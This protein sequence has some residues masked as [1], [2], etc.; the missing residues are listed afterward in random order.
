MSD[1]GNGNGFDLAEFIDDKSSLFVTMGVFGALALYISETAPAELTEASAMI[2]VGF[3]ASFL[4]AMLI[5]ALIYRDLR[6][7]FG[8]WHD[9]IQAH[10]RFWENPALTAFTFLAIL[11]GMSVSFIFARH[12]PVILMIGFVAVSLLGY[13]IG[14][15]AFYWV[16]RRVPP[17]PVWRIGTV[18]TGSIAVL[19]LTVYL[20]TNILNVFQLTPINDL[21]LSDPVPVLIDIMLLLVAS[22]QSLAAMGILAGLLG[23]PLVIIDKIRGVSPYDEPA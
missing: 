13:T 9:L 21:T 7:E 11:L 20:R 16:G 6:D 5:F 3:A 17:T 2:R 14:M 1:S 10:T 8:S 18:I 22:L 19:M 12:Q 15:N 4:I 23:I